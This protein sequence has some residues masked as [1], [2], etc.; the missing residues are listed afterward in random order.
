MMKRML[1]FFS[2]AAAGT[3]DPT[4]AKPTARSAAKA[5]GAL[6]RLR[7]MPEEIWIVL[8]GTSWD[9]VAPASEVSACA[10]S[11]SSD[12]ASDKKCEGGVLQIQKKPQRNTDRGFF[13]HEYEEA[14]ASRDPSHRNTTTQEDAFKEQ[15]ARR[16]EPQPGCPLLALSGHARERE[17]GLLLT[18]SGHSVGPQNSW[19]VSGRLG[20]GCSGPE[21][22]SEI[23]KLI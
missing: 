9:G 10:L 4:A 18:Q 3:D 7:L 11:Q 1:G 5:V 16:A 14:W 20:T 23:L 8:M 6:V 22:H 17:Q 2:W 19:C 15:E 21:Q 12:F 13:H